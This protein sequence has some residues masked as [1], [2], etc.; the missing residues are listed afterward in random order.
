MAGERNIA[1]RPTL[2]LLCDAIREGL[3]TLPLVSALADDL[4]TSQ[5]RLPFQPGG[6][7]RWAAENDLV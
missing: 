4:L 3:L 1:I 5:Y 2:A 7:E 6:F